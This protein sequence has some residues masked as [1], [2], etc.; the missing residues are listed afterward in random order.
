M[1]CCCYSLPRF[2]SGGK[3]VISE[4]FQHVA[5]AALRGLLVPVVAVGI[6]KA[7]PVDRLHQLRHLVVAVIGPSELV[8]VPVPVRLPDPDQPVA[9][10][11]VVALG[12]YPRPICDR[13]AGEGR[14]VLLRS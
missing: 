9:G 5:I 4:A 3:P 10:V 8:L 6:G 2:G 7:L 11:V 12:I 13:A 1:R 14:F